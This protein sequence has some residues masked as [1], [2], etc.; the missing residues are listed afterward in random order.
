MLWEWVLKVE[1][2]DWVG[3]GCTG[4]RVRRRVAWEREGS[5]ASRF[6]AGWGVSCVFLLRGGFDMLGG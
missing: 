6:M 5:E 3:F 4:P 2:L 1:E